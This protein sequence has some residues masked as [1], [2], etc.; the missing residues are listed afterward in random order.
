MTELG[1]AVAVF[2]LTHLIPAI[3]PLRAVLVRVFGER[4]YIVLFSILSLAVIVWL[5]FAYAGAPYVELW[6]YI[7]ELRWLPIIVM[8]IACILVVAGLSSRNPFSLGLGS[9]GFDPLKPGITAVTRHPAI[10][11]LVLWS[12][13]HI[14]VNGDA[15]SLVLFGLLTGLGFGG[16]KSLDA[17]RRRSMGEAEWQDLL[18]RVNE[19]S[20]TTALAQT[21]PWRVLLGMALYGALLAAHEPVIGISPLP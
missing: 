3:R 2:V 12:A 6:P 13:L 15:A 16:P 21:G 17:K 4:L 14:P 5:G 1:L 11:G 10:W 8:P 19:T 18:T 20:F 9:D 7:P